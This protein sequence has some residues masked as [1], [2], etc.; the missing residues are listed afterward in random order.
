MPQ[1]RELLVPRSWPR[2]HLMASRCAAELV[3]AEGGGGI[4]KQSAGRQLASRHFHCSDI[5]D[6]SNALKLQP[7]V[8]DR[9][10]GDAD[11]CENDDRCIFIIQAYLQS[12]WEICHGSISVL[13]CF[14]DALLSEAL[15]YHF[16]SSNSSRSHTLNLF[17]NGSLMVWNDYMQINIKPVNHTNVSMLTRVTKTTFSS[18]SAMRSI[19]AA[20]VSIL[21]TRVY[22]RLMDVINDITFAWL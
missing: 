19:L 9:Q 5:G 3:I 12:H 22:V 15:L 4:R 10:N 7:L 11:D 20:H 2:P 18:K 13:P 1:W 8:H 17:K 16:C 6:K 21:N 14:C